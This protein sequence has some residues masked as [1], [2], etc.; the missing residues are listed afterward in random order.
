MKLMVAILH[1]TDGES[2]LQALTESGLRVTRVAAAGGFLRR[3]NVTLLIGVDEKQIAE[4]MQ[5]LRE[6]STPVID[7]G[8]KHA[9]VFVLNVDQ[10]EQI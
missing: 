9:T 4:A 8:Q 10:F 5:I 1:N 6:H 7:P 2:T 3:S